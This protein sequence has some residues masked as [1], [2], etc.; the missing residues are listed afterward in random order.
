MPG[1]VGFIAWSRPSVAVL[2]AKG[3]IRINTGIHPVASRIVRPV[4]ARELDLA[5]RYRGADGAAV[6]VTWLKYR[7][8]PAAHRG[9]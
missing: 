5:G 1:L 9:C 6:I 2:A 3:R 4:L 8:G 7:S